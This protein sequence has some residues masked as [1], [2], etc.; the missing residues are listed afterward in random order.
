MEGFAFETELVDHMSGPAGKEAESLEN[1]AKAAMH[2]EGAVHGLG[3][4]HKHASAEILTAKGF[5][6]EFGHSLVPEVALGELAA[7]GVKKIAE[8]AVEVAETFGELAVEG[9]HFALEMSEFKENA[10]AAYTIVKGTA[11]EGEETFQQIEE[12]G[13]AIHAPVEKAQNMAQQLMQEG[14]ENTQAVKDVIQSVTELQRTGNE[15]GADRLQTLIERSLAAGTFT[16]KGKALAGTGI[17][18]PALVQQLATDLHQPLAR[19][20]EELKAGKIVAEEGISA[21]ESVFYKSKIH[22]IAEEKFSLGDLAT[23]MRN[24]FKGMFEDFDVSPIMDPLR[25]LATLIDGNTASGRLLGTTIHMGFQGL[26]DITGDAIEEVTLF[27]LNLEKWALKGLLAVMPL[28]RMLGEVVELGQKVRE[29]LG[30]KGETYGV[31]ILKGF[32]EWRHRIGGRVEPGEPGFVGPVQAP[33]DEAHK[34]G[35]QIADGLVGGV[36][37]GLGIHSPSAVMAELGHHAADGFAIGVDQ[38]TRD[39]PES[40]SVTVENGAIQVTVHAPQAHATA[41]EIR[42][43]TTSALEDVLEQLILELGG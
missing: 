43:V 33:V 3:E 16:V 7:E 20:K 31:G 26:I 8:S 14:L 40:R 39:M 23:D 41:E 37:D 32:D 34:A 30:I 36:K 12:L 9:V 13:L 10:I 22:Q 21:L 25:D 17:Q 35:K 18:M 29:A 38:G 42:E 4:A 11:A 24:S 15:R 27:G 28:I 6:R 2:A 5:M 19:V 1:L